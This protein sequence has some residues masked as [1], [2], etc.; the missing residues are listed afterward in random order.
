MEY[1]MLMGL[2]V[3]FGTFKISSIVT[4]LEVKRE[5]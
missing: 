1:L 4:Y 5:V 2:Y 3:H